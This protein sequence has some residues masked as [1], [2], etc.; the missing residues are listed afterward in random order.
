MQER[1]VAEADDQA[2]RDLRRF[3][4]SAWTDYQLG[5]WS[6]LSLVGGVFLILRDRPI[7]WG[8]L[9]VA[10]VY[11]LGI[12]AVRKNRSR[13]RRL[14]GD[15]GRTEMPARFTAGAARSYRY[16][17][18]GATGY[19]GIQIVQYAYPRTLP[20]AASA[21][22]ALFALVMIVGI[23]GF[24]IIRVRMYLKGDDLAPKVD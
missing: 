11:A 9:G 15:R 22:I 13:M 24:A 12:A 16:A 21:T 23:G 8:W 6:L 2:L 18:V 4:E 7:G 19:A 14:L 3:A 5:I 20:V 1:R 10:V 17:A